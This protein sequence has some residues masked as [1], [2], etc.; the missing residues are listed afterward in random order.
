MA[1]VLTKEI[2][3]IKLRTELVVASTELVVASR[4]DLNKC[5]FNFPFSNSMIITGTTVQPFLL[6]FDQT[7]SYRVVMNIIQPLLQNP[8]SVQL[9]R[10]VMLLPKLKI[11]ISFIVVPSFIKQSNEPR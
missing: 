2:R 6:F 8:V 1:N 7:L 11:I 4:Y 10:M 5:Q 3:I 9:N